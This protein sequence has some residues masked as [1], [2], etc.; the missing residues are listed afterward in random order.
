MARRVMFGVLIV[1]ILL[2]AKLFFVRPTSVDLELD[3]GHPA[4]A[5][6]AATLVFTD[7]NDRVARALE[8]SY[9]T[10]A[11]PHDTR[12]LRLKPGDY[13]VG[14]RLTLE[15]APERTLSRPLHVGDA[16]KYPLSLE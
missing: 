15:G 9:P 7:A 4:A 6:R 2:A 12:Q 8:L 13:S 16:G 10:G 11:P 3:F 5:V 14:V 1:A